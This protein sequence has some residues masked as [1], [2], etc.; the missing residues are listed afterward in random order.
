MIKKS[1]NLPGWQ[2]KLATTNQKWLSQDANFS[3]WLPPRKKSKISI[4]FFQTYW[5]SKNPTIWLVDSILG[6]NWRIRF[7]L[8]MQRSKNTVRCQFSAWKAHQL[9]NFVAKIK[10]SYFT[11]I[12]GNFPQNEN[13]SAFDRRDPLPSSKIS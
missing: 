5:W 9:I 12:V 8:D 7:F 11:R 4:D 1:S 3:W 2:A 6:H 10:K 13:I